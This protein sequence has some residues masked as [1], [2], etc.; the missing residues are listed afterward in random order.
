LKEHGA[1]VGKGTLSLV[2][3]GVRSGKSNFAQALAIE[4]G[5]AEVMFVATAECRDEEM[6]QRIERHQQ[7]RPSAWQTVEAPRDPVSVLETM[8]RL[9]KVVLLDCMTVLVS[10]LLCDNEHQANDSLERKTIA[11][12]ESLAKLVEHS[13]S[14]WIIV[15]G[16]V[17]SGIV[18]ASPLGRAFRDLLGFANQSLAGRADAVY[19]LVAGQAIPLHRINVTV[20]EAAKELGVHR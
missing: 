11:L 19:L 1:S 14:H 3:G 17:G 15:S 12:V 20:K 10:N 6:K 16:E 2:L 8:A 9:P 7:S 18:P 5:G 4:L 13:S